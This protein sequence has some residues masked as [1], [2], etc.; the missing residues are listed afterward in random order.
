MNLN[1][2]NKININK[3][4]ELKNN[5]GQYKMVLCN[6]LKSGDL[7]IAINEREYERLIN[8]YRCFLVDENSEIKVFRQNYKDKSDELFYFRKMFANE[9][10]H[11]YEI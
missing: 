10:A 9:F 8:I 5:N 1:E 4:F 6:A 2:K 3:M 7:E 11:Y